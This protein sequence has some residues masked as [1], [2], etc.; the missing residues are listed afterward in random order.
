MQPPRTGS[1]SSIGHAA[2]LLTVVGFS[3]GALRGTA[4]AQVPEGRQRDPAV[5][6]P[7]QAGDYQHDL[8]ARATSVRS[9]GSIDVDGR[10]DEAVWSQAV[11]LTDFVQELPLEGQPAT[12][13]SEFRIAYDDDAIYVGAMLY[14]DGPL[15]PRMT[16]RDAGR[17]DFDFFTVAFD[18]FHDHETS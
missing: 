16:R 1:S 4:G 15:T 12:Q 7:T 2:I 13:R 17:A 9:A 11:P 14:D 18:S 10:L 3:L 8:V 6:A 5:P